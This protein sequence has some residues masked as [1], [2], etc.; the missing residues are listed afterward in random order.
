MENKQLAIYLSVQIGKA[1]FRQNLFKIKTVATT[2]HQSNI[3]EL[4]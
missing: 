3:L 2:I 1:R 4:R